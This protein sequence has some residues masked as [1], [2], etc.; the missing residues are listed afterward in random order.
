VRPADGHVFAYDG[1]LA[2]LRPLANLASFS[3]LPFDVSS[4]LHST[5]LRMLSKIA[6]VAVLFV[7]LASTVAHLSSYGPFTIQEANGPAGD[8][9]GLCYNP[10]DVY[11]NLEIRACRLD[12]YGTVGSVF[13]FA[14]SYISLKYTLSG[15]SVLTRLTMKDRQSDFVASSF[16]RAMDVSSTQTNLRKCQRCFH[17]NRTSARNA[18]SL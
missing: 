6:F 18:C 10:D 5:P 15:T 3:R 13:F 9:Y 2:V 16:A 1:E 17:F 4:Q 11:T 12:I 14:L 8:D 7:Q